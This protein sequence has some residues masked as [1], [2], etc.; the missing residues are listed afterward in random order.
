MR[1]TPSLTRASVSLPSLQK[2][3]FGCIDEATQEKG[4]PKDGIFSRKWTTETK[5]HLHQQRERQWLRQKGKHQYIDFSDDERAELKG[6][7]DALATDDRISLDKLED[8]LISLGLA[9]TQREVKQIV[10]KI[11]SNENGQLDFEE[12]LELFRKRT[13]SEMYQVFKAMIDGKFGDRNLNFQTVISA[14]RRQLF[15][16]AT[17]TRPMRPSR[18]PADEGT[19]SASHSVKIL[20]N[21]S[22]LQRARLA[23]AQARADA[24]G[25]PVDEYL[26][27]MDATGQ[28]PPGG[29][30]MVWRG[31]ADQCRLTPSR[32]SSAERGR[33][34]IGRRGHSPV[35]PP[36]PSAI[37]SD[38]IKVRV[39]KAKNRVSG[40]G[41]T[42]V[43]SAPALEE[44][45]RLGSSKED[46]GVLMQ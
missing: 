34:G 39:P 25:P 18:P 22:A 37:I 7:F 15:I 16:D 23:A 42:I 13:D 19:L 30:S 26:R 24:G 46:L 31:V 21:F 1:S 6:Y 4:P 3:S 9:S 28:V 38:I 32:P 2:N 40:F 41:N 29:L 17:M 36:S 11:D 33:R 45:T 10:A 44:G 20:D 5:R 8:M 12:Y 27:A 14:Y 35:R 43:I